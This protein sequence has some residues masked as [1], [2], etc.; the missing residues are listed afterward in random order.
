M[1]APLVRQVVWK[2]SLSVGCAVKL[3]CNN[4]WDGMPNSVVVCRYEAAG[5]FIG[6]YMEQVGAT[7]SVSDKASRLAALTSKVSKARK[8]KA[9]STLAA[10]K[11]A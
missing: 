10:T 7:C 6:Q 2:A 5:N 11:L 4:M 8:G 3:D 1:L 9:Q